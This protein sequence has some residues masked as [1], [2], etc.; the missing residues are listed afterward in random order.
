[1]K[2]SDDHDEGH[3]GADVGDGYKAYSATLSGW[4]I[5]VNDDAPRERRWR[6]V[7]PEFGTKYFDKHDKILEY[8]VKRIADL[9]R[10]LMSNAGLRP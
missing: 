7:H 2:E 10:M 1:V 9:F 6:A 3:R 4:K 8:T 5:S